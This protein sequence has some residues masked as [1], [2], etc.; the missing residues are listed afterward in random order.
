MHDDTDTDSWLPRGARP[1]EQ[2]TDAEW[3]FVGRQLIEG[4]QIRE[5]RNVPKGNGMLTEVFRR[6]W[7]DG[8][9]V[10]DQ[11]FQA[12]VE[13]RC[14]SAWHA[15]ATTTDR[16]CVNQGLMRLVLYDARR[17]SPTFGLVNELVHGLARPALIVVPPRVWHGVQNLLNRPSALLNLPDH[18]YRYDAPDHWRLPADSKEIPYTFRSAAAVAGAG[19]GHD[20]I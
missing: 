16:L 19:H 17:E 10:V 6:D 7:F 2:S 4:V 18:G 15:H 20:D 14:V 13:S 3:N 11:V 12:V 5:V 9:V 8:D 1:D